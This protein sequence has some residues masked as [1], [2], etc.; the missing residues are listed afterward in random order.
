MGICIHEN[1]SEEQPAGCTIQR[2]VSVAG[3]RPSDPFHLVRDDSNLIKNI[4][5]FLYL[6]KL[7]C[8]ENL[9]STAC[10]STDTLTKFFIGQ[11]YFF[12]K[13]ILLLFV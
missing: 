6:F 8:A 9:F 2:G 10:F 7:R 3:A 1:E 12:K 5:Q 13:Y 11:F 4:F